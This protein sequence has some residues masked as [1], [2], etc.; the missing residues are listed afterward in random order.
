MND[1]NY[2]K[3]RDELINRREGLWY[4]EKGR[5]TLLKELWMMANDPPRH[6]TRSIAIISPANGGK[7]S[8]IRRY[9]RLHPVKKRDEY[10]EIPSICINMAALERVSDLSVELL[11]A[12]RALEPYPNTHKKRLK[13]FV[14]IAEGV[15]LGIIFLDEFHDCIGTDGRGRPF[16]RCIK[17]L[18]LKGFHVVPVGTDKLS[19]VLLQD[20]QLSSRFNLKKGVVKPI[21]NK[22]DVKSIALEVTQLKNSDVTDATICLIIENTG[23]II[24]DMLDA[25]E[26]TFMI[27]HDLKY[28]SFID[29][30]SNRGLI[31]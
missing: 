11:T 28:E 23:G 2:K 14:K 31:Q 5:N 8:L 4:P 10:L 19:E 25:I 22:S 30:F 13:S 27:K 6:R 16:L 9:M 12:V 18:L 20:A 24:G 7:S 26:E 21:K 15:K 3:R 17:D 29:Y 1:D